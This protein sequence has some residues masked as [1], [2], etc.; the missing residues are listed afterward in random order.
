MLPRVFFLFLCLLS[1]IRL[2]S[3]DALGNHFGSTISSS[4]DSSLTTNSSVCDSLNFPNVS[5]YQYNFPL[6]SKYGG[7]VGTGVFLPVYSSQSLFE[8]NSKIQTAVIV[9]HGLLR[10]ADEVFCLAVYNL[11]N[12]KNEDVIV[13]APWFGDVSL[14][15]SEWNSESYRPY[16][17]LSNSAYWSSSSWISGGDN[18]E[19]NGVPD[20]FTSSY[21]ALDELVATVSSSTIFPS[22]ELITMTGFS[23]GGQMVNRYAWATEIDSQSS[24]EEESEDE[25]A[26]EIKISFSSSTSPIISLEGEQSSRGSKA[27]L[28]EKSSASKIP[29]RYI[30]SDASS[31]L[32]LSEERPDA[33][34]LPSYNN[35]YGDDVT[36]NNFVIPANVDDC[37]GYDKWKYGISS[38]P[39]SGYRYIEA[40]TSKEGGI[41]NRT[42][43]YLKKD[44]RFVFGG[45]DSC[46][47]NAE[48]FVN[49]ASCYIDSVT[50]SPT[51]YGGTGC[52]DTYPDSISNDESNSCKSLLQGYDR[53]QR[54]M[55]YMS[56]LKWYESDYE[57]TYS[58]IPT[59]SHN[60]TA[61]FSS[62]V[63]QSWSYA[64]DTFDATFGSSI[65]GDATSSYFGLGGLVKSFYLFVGV[66]VTGFVSFI[67]IY[68]AF[69]LRL[70]RVNNASKAGDKRVTENDNNSGD[71][72][73]TYGTNDFLVYNTEEQRLIS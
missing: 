11:G 55:M 19:G 71:Y 54:G 6:T 58:I 67:G 69:R 5:L 7:E 63:F 34:C 62:D 37:D 20:D 73:S 22:M 46:N 23:A 43:A 66:F 48:N 10:N 44:L 1:L 47:C 59:M 12:V 36:C 65:D 52:C 4:D 31:Y 32:Y 16:S 17:A 30:V 70:Y 49:D 50:C 60:S 29:M 45:A 33:S 18:S 42:E 35:G 53:L 40:I 61:F 24:S 28:T 25:E 2:P 39:S 64:S 15:G 27:K 68:A 8:S 72:S 57:P 51:E 14:S 9:I 26:D 41:G 21:D 13:I 56:Y 3:Y 38:Y